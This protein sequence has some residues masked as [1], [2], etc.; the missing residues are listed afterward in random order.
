MS[1][2]RKWLV[3]KHEKAQGDRHYPTISI[4]LIDDGI[5]SDTTDIP[6]LWKGRPFYAKG[7]EAESYEEYDS[8]PSPHGTK[9]AMCINQVCPSPMIKMYVARM[10]DSLSPN[11]PFTVRSAT[12]VG[13]PPFRHR[14]ISSYL[15]PYLGT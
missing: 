2:F 10:D 8:G 9:M 4:A 1:P 3:D 13:R 12:E 6:F 5:D 15:E 7:P 11:E 14:E